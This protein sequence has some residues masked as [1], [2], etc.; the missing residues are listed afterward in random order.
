MFSSKL[1]HEPTTLIKQEDLD[2]DASEDGLD[3]F[4]SRFTLHEKNPV[5]L[6]WT[7]VV[8]CLLVYVASAFLYRFTFCTFHI[9]PNGIEPIGEND[10]VWKGIDLAVDVL[11]WLDLF[12][13]F[14]MTY[15]DS[16]GRE[17]DSLC[18][19]AKKYLSFYFWINLL[20]CL[21]EQSFAAIFEAQAAED[22]A[23]TSQGVDFRVA[24]VY[25]LQRISRLARLARVTRLF[26]L[27][28]IMSTSHLWKRFQALRGVRVVNFIAGLVWALHLLAC[29]WYLCAALHDDVTQTWVA[30][31]SVNVDGTSLLEAA[32]FEQ[33][34][35]AMYFVLTVFTTVGFG[36]ISA[37]TEA[38]IGYV[39]LT[40]LVGAV[41]H[42]IIISE[43]I[44]IVTSTDEVQKVV[45][46]QLALIEAF[47]A[48]TN[49]APD[50]SKEMKSEISFRAKNW[51]MSFGFDKSEMKDLITGKYMPRWLIAKI[52]QSLFD[53][54]LLKNNFL[55]SIGNMPPRM[56][57][58]LAL[59][60]MSC[61]FE[62]GEVIYQMGDYPFNL[63]L[64][65]NGTFAY[66]ARA[67]PQ[68]G[69]DAMEPDEPKQLGSGD[70]G[71]VLKSFSLR[72]PS[73]SRQPSGPAV[74][75]SASAQHLF[76]YR[77]YSQTAYFGDIEMLAGKLRSS[78][79][80]CERRGTALTLHKKDFADISEM[81]PHFYS[82]W[83]SRSRHSEAFRAASLA[84]LNLGV[85]YRNLAAL[86]IQQFL[87]AKRGQ[88][89]PA[90]GANARKLSEISCQQALRG[91]NRAVPA[92]AAQGGEAQ[93]TLESLRQEIAGLRQE[94]RALVARADGASG[95][96]S[97]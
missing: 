62:A 60:L 70:A 51:A 84:K 19:I 42:S 97:L 29:G 85:S 44:G 3:H 71:E 63:F 61:D 31:R 17:V 50:T 20:A 91:G 46:K 79:A 26:K 65:V 41:V 11:F 1:F 78:T 7:V 52:P 68:G 86:K 28:Q 47:T 89:E 55:H 58:L 66:V 76:P 90:R 73:M 53:G 38:E 16:R 23:E 21:P 5:R 57:C 95:N 22:P 64:V 4:G 8:V 13:A 30:R 56:P 54:H 74:C 10:P 35:V 37:G 92:P 6:L 82:A 24:R 40:M 94:V 72:K 69:I 49:L 67:T 80:R 2:E 59:H 45:E 81:F 33:W 15:K 96:L 27:A 18:S 48:H 25:R 83:V 14:F 39:A 12:I 77:L 36:D 87:R 34:L 32:P 75:S 43:V 88:G 93:A 9:G